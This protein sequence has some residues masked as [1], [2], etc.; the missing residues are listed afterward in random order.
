MASQA[1][2]ITASLELGKGW[3]ELR[4]SELKGATNIQALPVGNST[5]KL[6][7][8]SP[9]SLVQL[10]KIKSKQ[11]KTFKDLFYI[12]HQ[13]RGGFVAFA[14]SSIYKQRSVKRK[15]IQK[16]PLPYGVGIMIQ[17]LIN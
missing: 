2:Q 11:Q 6:G 9:S 15:K 10:L 12:L 1:R 16:L 5:A 7:S 17:P 4:T 13:E 14:S 3:Y 8:P